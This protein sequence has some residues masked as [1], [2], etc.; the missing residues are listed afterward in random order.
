MPMLIDMDMDESPIDAALPCQHSQ[1]P[2][3]S[4]EEQ[5]LLGAD[6]S[7]SDTGTS[8]LIARSGLCTR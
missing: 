8:A 4:L 5:Y 3:A 7:G 2:H 6:S 1:S